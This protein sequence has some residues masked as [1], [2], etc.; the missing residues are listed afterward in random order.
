MFRFSQ[1][2]PILLPRKTL[3]SGLT[4]I[5]FVPGMSRCSS[6]ANYRT[7]EPSG[8]C[9]LGDCRHIYTPIHSPPLHA[10]WHVAELHVLDGACGEALQHQ[11][12]GR[13]LLLGTHQARRVHPRGAARAVR[14]TVHQPRRRRSVLGGRREGMSGPL[15]VPES[16]AEL[17]D[18]A[19]HEFVYRALRSI[20]RC[21][22]FVLP[23][24]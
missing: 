8:L 3:S 4:V 11:P 7:T 14:E 24:I 10:G 19:V 5:H 15:Q 2:A 18:C 12:S 20:L 17:W 1:M 16:E 6:C 13:F 23:D 22:L 9:L 21:A